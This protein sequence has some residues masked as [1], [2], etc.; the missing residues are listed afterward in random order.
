MAVGSFADQFFDTVSIHVYGGMRTPREGS[1]TR[2]VKIG[3]LYGGQVYFYRGISIDK[4]ASPAKVR[5][6]SNLCS[7]WQCKQA[8]RS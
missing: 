3:V 4:Q 8:K 2:Q 6:G 7:S 1:F 5:A